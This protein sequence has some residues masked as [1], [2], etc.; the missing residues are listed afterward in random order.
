MGSAPKAK[1]TTKVALIGLTPA[2]AQVFSNSFR[3]F[4]IEPVIFEKGTRASAQDFRAC[5]VQLGPNSRTL[6]QR[7]RSS[8]ASQRICRAM[9][10]WD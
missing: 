1:P 4:S 5:V 2:T 8:A 10:A 7:L 9:P 3:H 6:V